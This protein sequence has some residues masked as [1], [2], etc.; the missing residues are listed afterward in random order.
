MPVENGRTVLVWTPAARPPARCGRRCCR[1]PRSSTGPLCRA[2]RPGSGRRTA[3][4]GARRSATPLQPSHGRSIYFH[5]PPWIFH[6]WCIFYAQGLRQIDATTLVYSHRGRPGPGLSLGQRELGLPASAG[7][8]R[9]VGRDR[10]C[11][12][13]VSDTSTTRTLQRQKARAHTWVLNPFS[14]MPREDFLGSRQVHP[15]VC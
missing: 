15:A 7:G 9:R 10:R 4:S 8:R 5:A 1:A 14:E 6:A 3:A 11:L 13:P 2:S 12:R